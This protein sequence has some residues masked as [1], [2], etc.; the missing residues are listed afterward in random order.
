MARW[1]QWPCIMRFSILFLASSVSFVFACGG[2]L[3]PDPTKK[4]APQAGAQTGSS[5]NANEGSSG[6]AQGTAVTGD[7]GFVAGCYELEVVEVDAQPNGDFFACNMNAGESTKRF[8]VLALSP[9]AAPNGADEYCNA[10]LESPS[11]CFSSR[12]C[13]QGGSGSDKHIDSKTEVQV[14]SYGFDVTLTRTFYEGVTSSLC[15]TRTTAKLR[16]AGACQ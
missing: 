10:A 16:P 15:K 1:L 11:R 3:E 6:A 13:Q 8:E 12:Q 9:T 14:T 4:V 7:C 5:D 2:Q